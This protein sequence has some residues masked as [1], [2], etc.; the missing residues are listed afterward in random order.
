M[1]KTRTRLLRAIVA[2]AAAVAAG[3]PAHAHPHVWVTVEATLL[4]GNGAFT[5]VHH[6][7]TFDE[8]Y[9]TQAIEG[10][11]KN[12]DGTYDRAELAELAKVNVEALKDFD[13]FTFPTLA[14][15]ALKL[16]APP[17]DYWMEH[18]DGVLSLNFTVPFASPVLTDAK[19]LAFSIYD[20]SFFIAF[21][22]AKTGNPVRLGGGAPK[23]CALQVEAPDQRDTAA[24]GPMS[25]L[26]GVVSLGRTI[27]VT[28][29]P[30]AVLAPSKK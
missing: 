8:S 2:V 1:L 5:A 21:D 29:P 18:K 12:N 17:D 24:L 20:P 4:Y 6:K 19:G 7:W 22:L 11:D 26:G 10:L 16:A 27:S 14:G 23:G 3:V 30:T 9:T 15:Q 25:Q 28:C 13:Y